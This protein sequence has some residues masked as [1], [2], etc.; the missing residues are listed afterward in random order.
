V[1]NSQKLSLAGAAAWLIALAVQVSGYTNPYL[2]VVL[3]LIGMACFVGAIWDWSRQ[4]GWLP[5]LFRDVRIPYVKI[6]ILANA[7]GWNLNDDS[8]QSI[9]RAYDLEK[10]MRQAASDGDLFVW[11]RRCETPF[12]SNPLILIPKE[13]F[14]D[15]GFEFHYGYLTRDNVENISTYTWKPEAGKKKDSFSGQN[16]CD[17]YVSRRG[18]NRLLRSAKPSDGSVC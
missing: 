11:G 8:S 4:R 1:S 7:R 15:S 18:I 14:A 5:I 2:A 6:R 10:A 16:Y 13:H 12:G 9:N 17:L 3:L